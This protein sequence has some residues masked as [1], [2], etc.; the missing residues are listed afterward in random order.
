[1][2]VMQRAAHCPDSVNLYALPIGLLT[3]C[4]TLS[5]SSCR[6]L[7]I[8]GSITRVEFDLLPNGTRSVRQNDA[9]QHIRHRWPLL[10]RA[11]FAHVDFRKV[12]LCR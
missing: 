8:S 5:G 3:I 10:G 1:M 2:T 7:G 6:E 9:L 12:P 11:H 4:E